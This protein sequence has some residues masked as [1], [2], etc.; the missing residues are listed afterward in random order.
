MKN[1]EEDDAAVTV[2]NDNIYR[3]QGTQQGVGST[4][5]VPV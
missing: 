4:G 5:V 1:E 3:A 2:D